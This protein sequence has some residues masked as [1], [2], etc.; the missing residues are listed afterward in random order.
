MT[1][2]SNNLAD[3][4]ERVKEADEASISAEKTFIE[5]SIDAGTLLLQAKEECPHG[6]WA[7]FLVRTGVHE[8]KA[9]RLMQLARSGLKPDT[10]SDLG[11]IKAAL[12]FIADNDLP[13][14]SDYLVAWFEGSSWPVPLTL[15]WQSDVRP[16][17]FF[18]YQFPHTEEW[19]SRWFSKPIRADAVW[20]AL[21]YMVDGKLKELNFTTVPQ[22]GYYGIAELVS[23][24]MGDVLERDP[25]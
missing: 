10:V 12:E 4:A 18:F 11:G 6:D 5:K 13:K 8:R 9:R 2:L 1:S 17:F 15:I 24:D 14:P 25:H 21:D 22:A 19:N 23:E 16:G 3:L 20:A 7:P